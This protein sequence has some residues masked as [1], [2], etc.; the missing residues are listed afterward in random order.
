MQ[1]VSPALLNADLGQQINFTA[2]GDGYIAA[3]VAMTLRLGNAPLGTGTLAYAKSTAAAPSTFT[4]TTLPV[5]LEAGA[6]LKVTASGVGDKLAV[7]FFRS[8]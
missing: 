5:T 1:K 8:A 2:N 6:W 4:S 3:G 7:H